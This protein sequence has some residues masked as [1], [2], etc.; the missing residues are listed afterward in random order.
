MA[1]DKV[2]KDIIDSARREADALIERAEEEKKAILGESEEQISKM[3]KAQ[4]KDLED[5]L[6]RL[7][8]QEISSAELE[9]KKIVLNKKKEILDRTFEEALSELS[10]MP[11]NDKARVY[12]KSIDAA[13]AAFPR[14]KVFC[15]RGDSGLLN[16]IQGLAA[17]NEMDIE[18][19]LILENEDGSVRLD[20]RFKTILE[21]IWEQELKEVSEILFG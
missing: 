11:S 13:K 21:G 3:R 10:A 20:Y 5:T 19:G 1:L 17:V 18:A 15:P 9:A 14:P 12:R 8:R 16:G 7:R 6:K 2:V 4:E